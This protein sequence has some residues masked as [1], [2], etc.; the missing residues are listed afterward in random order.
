MNSVPQP[1]KKDKKY[2]SWPNQPMACERLIHYSSGLLIWSCNSV[3]RTRLVGVLNDLFVS[4]SDRLLPCLHLHCVSLQAATVHVYGFLFVPQRI[5]WNWIA[6]T[7]SALNI[8]AGCLMN[9]IQNTSKR[10]ILTLIW[11]WRAADRRYSIN[12]GS[13]SCTPE[14]ICYVF[15]WLYKG[16]WICNWINCK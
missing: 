15:W 9:L 13:G 4:L 1:N 14:R 10:P 3:D 2:L 16:V 8:V 7:E 6:C 5:V 11:L 12:I